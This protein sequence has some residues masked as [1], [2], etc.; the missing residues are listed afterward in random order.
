MDTKGERSGGLYLNICFLIFLEFFCSIESSCLSFFS[1]PSMYAKEVNRQLPPPP[2]SISL[3]KEPIF[4]SLLLTFPN[5]YP[6]IFSSSSS[7]SITIAVCLVFPF[8]NLG[9]LLFEEFFLFSDFFLII[10]LGFCSIILKNFS[11]DFIVC[12]IQILKLAFLSDGF[13]II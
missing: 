6:P 9:S 11:N 7:S 5:S 4:L 1:I 13:I 10:N 8:F 3:N 2:V 12:S